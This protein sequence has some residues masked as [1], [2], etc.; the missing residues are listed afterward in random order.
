MIY[1][2]PITTMPLRGLSPDPALLHEK[3]GTLYTVPE[4]LRGQL[5]AQ[6]RFLVAVATAKK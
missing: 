2:R 3:S 4:F 1:H 5:L 6:S